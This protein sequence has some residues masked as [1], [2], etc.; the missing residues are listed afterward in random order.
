MKQ[1]LHNAG[2]EGTRSRK[3]RKK[4]GKKGDPLLDIGRFFEIGVH[5]PSYPRAGSVQE[6]GKAR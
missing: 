3:S 6:S 1:K 4:K 5:N 2:V